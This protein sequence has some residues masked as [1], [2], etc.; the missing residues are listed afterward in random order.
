[1]RDIGTRDSFEFNT[2]PIKYQNIYGSHQ[3]KEF[4]IYP[5]WS[6]EWDYKIL[7]IFLNELRFFGQAIS[8][9]TRK[10]AKKDEN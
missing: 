10:V 1:M 2:R 6:F 3:L 9:P 8:K 5:Y 4:G 7:S